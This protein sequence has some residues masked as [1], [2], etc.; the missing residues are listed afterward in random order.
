MPGATRL[1]DHPVIGRR[2]FHPRPTTAAPTLVVEAGGYQL[3]CHVQ[4]PHPNGGWV[5]YFH[6]NGELAA[7]CDRYCSDLFTQAG[8]NVCFIE[9]RGYGASDGE[10]TL[11]AMLG[12]GER[13]VAALGVPAG[14]VVAF[15]RS[16]GS[17]YAIELAR[18]LPAIGGVVLE[19]GI[20]AISDLWPLAQ[21]AEEI[22][23]EPA[24]IDQEIA[25]DFDHQAKLGAYNGPLLVLH[26]AGDTLVD[27][28]HAER[29][30][31]WASGP[32]KRLVLLPRG[33]HNTILSANLTEYVAE[34]QGFLRRVG[35]S[36]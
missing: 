34:L 15:G 14:R 2:V 31:A 26:A 33:S 1:L 9:Y 35:P 3:G 20:A 23:C 27:A 17:L 19:S 10:P 7:E 4:R 21:K 30:H 5:V 36:N 25:A 6:G 8:F 11:S 29:L 28:S 22:G 12:D 18:R 16:L 13:V 24:A 32:D